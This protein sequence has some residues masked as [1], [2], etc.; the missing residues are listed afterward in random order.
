MNGKREVGGCDFRNIF[1]ALSQC[2]AF[3]VV[4]LLKVAFRTGNH[5]QK[6]SPHN[7]LKVILNGYVLKDCLMVSY[8]QKVENIL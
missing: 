8:Q 6:V 1:F 2:S 5:K 7:A 4:I 3:C